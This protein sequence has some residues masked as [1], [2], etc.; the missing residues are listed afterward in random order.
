MKRNLLWIFLCCTI[1]L[2]SLL[3]CK[4]QD[5]SLI[6]SNTA[7]EQKTSVLSWLDANAEKFSNETDRKTISRL[8][9]SLVFSGMR[10]EQISGGK[11]MT[12]VP[13]EDS[14]RTFR[15]KTGQ[16][17]GE[18]LLVIRQSEDGSYSTGHIVEVS[19]AGQAG[20][21]SA[22][23]IQKLQN[24]L[25]HEYTGRFRLLTINNYLLVEK[26]FER[27][28]LKSLTHIEQRNQG[29]VMEGAKNPPLASRCPE[30]HCIDWYLV[31]I[32]YTPSGQVQSITVEYAFTT[33]DDNLPGGGGGGGGTTDPDDGSTNAPTGTED[34]YTTNVMTEQDENGGIHI[35]EGV[36]S[37]A[38]GITYYLSCKVQR[39]NNQVVNVVRFGVQADQVSASY[40]DGLYNITRTLS[41]NSQTSGYSLVG[42]NH[43]YA[44]W[45]WNTQ[46][47]YTYLGIP[48]TH[49][50]TYPK[51]GM[52][53]F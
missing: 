5:S 2:S 25:P 45:T 21:I 38:P 47:N 8:K 27:G 46:A 3:S 48:D 36:P 41:V 20:N 43:G 24:D 30:C 13:I 26:E 10:T 32:Y 4:K 1:G 53:G 49:S 44:Y 42:L 18:K 31:T 34:T 29:E 12:I 50:R 23:L 14:F 51:S 7:Q 19:R 17:Q 35:P 28:T 6:T 22:N 40:Y 33:C 11:K 52:A 15:S 37:N 39:Q 16:Q 9:T